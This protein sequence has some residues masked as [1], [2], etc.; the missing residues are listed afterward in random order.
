MV[1]KMQK[2]FSISLKALQ[3]YKARHQYATDKGWA[4]KQIESMC[5]L[6]QQ[7]GSYTLSRYS[8]I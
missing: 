3:D 2:V 1:K 4:A 5:N 8:G 6:Y 7:L